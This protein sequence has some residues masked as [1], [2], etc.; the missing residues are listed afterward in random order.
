MAFWV[1][2]LLFDMP[3]A[4]VVYYDNT[5]GG[6]INVQPKKPV[7]REKDAALPRDVVGT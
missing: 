4:W 2:W 7:V 6:D 1:V 3:T 5:N